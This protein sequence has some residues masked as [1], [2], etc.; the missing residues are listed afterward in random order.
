L[1]SIL[2]NVAVQL[3]LKVA[4]TKL[5]KVEFS[6]LLEHSWLLIKTPE[7]L[8]GV[9]FSALSAI[10]YFL[11]LTRLNLSVAGPA[12]ALIYIFSVV[13]GHFIFKEAVPFKHLVG[14]GFIVCGVVLVGS[15]N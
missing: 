4:G 6:H 12:S 10:A 13:M 3:F 7:L 15:K 1:V 9:L 8:A 11:A 14:L 2:L 5:G